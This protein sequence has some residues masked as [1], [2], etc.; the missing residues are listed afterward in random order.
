[1]ILQFVIF[2]IYFFNFLLNNFFHTLLLNYN[3]PRYSTDLANSDNCNLPII[4]NVANDKID[5]IPSFKLDLDFS[6]IK[7]KNT[8][9]ATENYYNIEK[10]HPKFLN[11]DLDILKNNISQ[12]KHINKK[13]NLKFIYLIRDPIEAINSIYNY[14]QRNS[15]WGSKQANN[16]NELLDVQIKTLEFIEES[17]F[18]GI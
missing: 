5:M 7:K 10:I 9:E 12:L 8:K 3:L 18:V 14:N 15:E 16:V 1:L 2:K 13:I 6:K 11:Y 4:S 17:H